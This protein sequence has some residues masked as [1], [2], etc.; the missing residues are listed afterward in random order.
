MHFGNCHTECNH[1]FGLAL[2]W[3]SSSQT[4]SL[5]TL[6]YAGLHHPPDLPYPVPFYH[7]ASLTKPPGHSSWYVKVTLPDT[8]VE[9][10]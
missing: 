10:V 6:R 1:V 2:V 9:L 3:M 4:F 7:V 5:Q 8:G